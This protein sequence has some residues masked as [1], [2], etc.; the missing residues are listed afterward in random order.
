V[1]IEEYLL[2]HFNITRR[3][4]CIT[5]DYVILYQWEA[6][7]MRCRKCGSE[8]NVKNGKRN[9]AQCYKCK[10]CGFQFTKETAKGIE[11]GKR[12]NA[13]LLYVL[14]LFMNS[15]ARI[16]QV[17]PS[18]VLYWVRNFTLKVYEKPLPEGSV[19]LNLTR[20]GII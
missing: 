11:A 1:H 3:E 5:N 17:H 4:Y 7:V 19:A 2:K 15:I 16:Y 8:K 10:D 14:G 6:D 18:S 20:C 9:G 13:I 12:A